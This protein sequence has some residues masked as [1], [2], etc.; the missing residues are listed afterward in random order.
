MCCERARN[1]RN[2]RDVSFTYLYNNDR[3]TRKT[4]SIRIFC[5]RLDTR[6]GDT[7][8]TGSTD[9]EADS[10]TMKTSEEVTDFEKEF[11]PDD[12]G[13]RKSNAKHKMYINGNRNENKNLVQVHVNTVGIVRVCVHVEREQSFCFFIF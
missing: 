8:L 2:K 10:K 12:V 3:R 11:R 9:E 6:E 4:E 1:V 5:L 7:D 13:K